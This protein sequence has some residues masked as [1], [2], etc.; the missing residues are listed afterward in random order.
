MKK[1]NVIVF[2]LFLLGG[3]VVGSLIAQ[4]CQNV[5]FLSWLAF[6]L[7]FSVGG[8]TPIL[9]DL[10]VVKFYL[11][12]TLSLNIAVIFLSGCPCSFTGLL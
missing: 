2:L 8:N 11:G 3:I 12:L 5:G 7:D 4:V 1:Q 10:H 9:I 6:G